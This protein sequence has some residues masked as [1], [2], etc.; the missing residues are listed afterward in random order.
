MHWSD[1]LCCFYMT[2][3]ERM[4]EWLTLQKQSARKMMT[5]AHSRAL[6]TSYEFSNQ[7]HPI[8]FTFPGSFNRCVPFTAFDNSYFN[9][10][11]KI[12]LFQ[13]TLRATS[14]DK[15]KRT[16]SQQKISI[17]PFN[18]PANIITLSFLSYRLCRFVSTIVWVWFWEFRSKIKRSS[19]VFQHHHNIGINDYYGIIWIVNEFYRKVH[20]KW[21]ERWKD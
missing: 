20:R 11:C 17:N 3:K 14:T 8:E 7:Y 1:V 18:F 5:L 21:N 9:H 19:N 6:Q 2:A 15:E 13:I 16:L 4:Y 12:A 10:I